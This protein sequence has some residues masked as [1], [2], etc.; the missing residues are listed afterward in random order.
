MVTPVLNILIYIWTKYNPVA[1]VLNPW[2]MW[3][4]YK[5][6]NFKWISVID[7]LGLSCKITLRW[8]PQ[9]LIDGK[10]T[11]APDLMCYMSSLGHNELRIQKKT[12]IILII[13]HEICCDETSVKSW[14]SSTGN[15]VTD[16]MCQ[17]GCIAFAFD[18]FRYVS[19]MKCH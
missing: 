11:L 14:W 10:S 8:I 19:M 5:M 15:M 9:V 13:C 7:V 18:D 6:Y 17:N 12:M 16:F 2:G 1:L 4:W 3:L